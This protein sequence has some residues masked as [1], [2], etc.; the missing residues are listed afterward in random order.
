MA[1]RLTGG[2]AKVSVEPHRCSAAFL[3][4]LSHSRPRSLAHRS[5]RRNPQLLG[6]WS[7]VAGDPQVCQGTRLDSF[8]LGADVRKEYGRS[9]ATP[10][11]GSPPLAR[12]SPGRHQSLRRRAQR[13]QPQALPMT[14]DPDRIIAAAKRRHQVLYSAWF[15]VRVARQKPVAAVVD[16]LKADS[17]RGHPFFRT[18][19]NSAV[20]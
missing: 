16:V 5:S 8:P 7:A 4:H 11:A 17:S 15:H 12:R 6:N 3:P 19:W 1:S 14:A 10:E 20:P 18:S 2:T 13:N 9:I